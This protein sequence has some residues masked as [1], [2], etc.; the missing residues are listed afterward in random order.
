MRVVSKIP[1]GSQPPAIVEAAMAGLDEASQS[2]PSGFPMSDLE[3]TLLSVA[4]REDAQSEV[5]VKVAAG[6]AFRDALTRAVP[7]KLE[8]IMSVDV[9][10]SEDYLGAVIGDLRQRR[11]HILD[12][13]SAGESRVAKARVPLSNM[14]GYATDLRSLTKGRST[15]TMEFHAY[16]NLEA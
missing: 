8:P 10:V 11:A 13:G 7:L 4:H 3:A 1:D 9:I 6:E 16:D 12:I 15:F 5:G 2:G 14:F